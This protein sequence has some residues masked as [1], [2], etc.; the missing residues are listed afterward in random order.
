[1][2]FHR[3][4]RLGKLL[5]DVYA[6]AAEKAEAIEYS[7]GR[8]PLFQPLHLQISAESDQKQSINQP[9]SRF[10]EGSKIRVTIFLYGYRNQVMA[11]GQIAS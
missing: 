1:M 2:Q 5:F 7:S 9:Y 11:M 10:L 6:Q 4:E 3:K 8:S